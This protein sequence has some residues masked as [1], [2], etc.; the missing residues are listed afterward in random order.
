MAGIIEQ[1][2]WRRARVA[3]L[4]DTMVED[5]RERG[6]DRRKSW[7]TSAYSGK[8]IDRNFAGN[9]YLEFVDTRT[10]E[11]VRTKNRVQAIQRLRLRAFV[12]VFGGGK[13][14]FRQSDIQ[15]AFDVDRKVAKRLTKRIN[16]L[17]GKQTVQIDQKGDGLGYDNAKYTLHLDFVPGD[18]EFV[19]RD[20]R[21]V[22]GGDR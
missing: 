20:L 8:P 14:Q 3:F 1:E 22:Q 12:S 6:L 11:V 10:G 5:R 18:P 16:H 7:S 17:F 13:S 19:V 2:L 15:R 21:E 9:D 4:F